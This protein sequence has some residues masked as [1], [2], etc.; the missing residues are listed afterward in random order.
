MRIAA[1]EGVEVVKM[2]GFDD[3]GAIADPL[4]FQER[5]LSRV[6]EILKIL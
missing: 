1:D 2:N 4:A 6:R 3:E 5:S